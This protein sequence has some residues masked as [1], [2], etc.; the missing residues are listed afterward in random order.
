MG[1]PPAPEGFANSQAV[2][3]AEVLRIRQERRQAGLEGLVGPLS[4]I[5]I[6][7]EPHE[8]R[9]A[10]GE[11][12]ARTGLDLEAAYEGPSYITCVLKAAGSAD[13]LVRSRRGGRSEN[14]FAPLNDRP[15]SRHLPNTRLETLLDG[16]CI[17][18]ETWLS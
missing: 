1:Q 7:T 14:P 13:V 9:A 11:L 8:Q 18:E 5:I 2:L 17:L 4:A 16:W 15:K 6:N 12:L 3:E 10:V